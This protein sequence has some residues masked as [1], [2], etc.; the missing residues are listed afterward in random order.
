MSRAGGILLCLRRYLL[1]AICCAR[2]KSLI[3]G[4]SCL[5][6]RALAGSSPRSGTVNEK[7]PHAWGLVNSWCAQGCSASPLCGSALARPACVGL[8]RSRRTPARPLLRSR[9]RGFE[10]LAPCRK[11]KSPVAGAWY[12][13]VRPGGLEPSTF[14]S[15]G[16]R[17]N[18]LSYGRSASGSIAQ[19]WRKPQREV[20]TS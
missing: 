2:I 11:R 19:G 12:S 7:G 20:T 18:P 15:G 16:R 1:C 13:L 3:F 14:C 10:P 5:T 4:T 6:A 17:S 8:A 9:P